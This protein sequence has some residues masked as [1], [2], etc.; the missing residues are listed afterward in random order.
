MTSLTGEA[1]DRSVCVTVSMVDCDDDDWNRRRAG[2][3]ERVVMGMN[4]RIR[5]A[6]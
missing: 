2:V 1:A 5:V 6:A 4:G 3:V